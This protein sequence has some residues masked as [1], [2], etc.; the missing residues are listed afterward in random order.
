MIKH[1]T[2]RAMQISTMEQWQIEQLHER[3][4][5]IGY[6]IPNWNIQN[7]FHLHSIKDNYGVP[8]DDLGQQA[9]YNNR[10]DSEIDRIGARKMTEGAE[11]HLEW[12]HAFDWAIL[13]S[14]ELLDWYHSKGKSGGLLQRL[15]KAMPM[16][17]L[18]LTK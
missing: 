14:K 5:R 6:Y 17:L 8:E 16:I 10:I 2:A 9:D 13:N 15:T 7:L 4:N 12:L 1:T 3:E 11:T 18:M